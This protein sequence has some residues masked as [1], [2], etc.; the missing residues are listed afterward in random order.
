MKAERIQVIVKQPLE[1]PELREIDN[2]LEAMR[3]IVGGSIEI[4]RFDPLGRVE[5]VCN[6]DFLALKMTPNVYLPEIESG[7]FGPLFIAAPQMTPDGV[8]FRSLTN[9]EAALW[10]SIF[11]I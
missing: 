8:E 2:T 4:V 10:M 5:L 9:S 1:A 6:D 7:I 11:A 3:E